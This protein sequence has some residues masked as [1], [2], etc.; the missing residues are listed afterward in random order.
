FWNTRDA[1]QGWPEGARLV[2]HFQRTEY[3][4][5]N[6]TLKE[7]QQGQQLV[8]PLASPRRLDPSR[9]EVTA[10]YFS[11]L[12]DRTVA[13]AADTLQATALVAE[14][15]IAA[16][17]YQAPFRTFRAFRD[18]LDDR[19]LVHIRYGAPSERLETTW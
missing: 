2:E 10:R 16:G 19:G 3:A 7:H 13:Q 18:R 9:D 1:A 5:A 17:R 12:R 8:S 4:V 15:A 14:A 11:E 6:Y